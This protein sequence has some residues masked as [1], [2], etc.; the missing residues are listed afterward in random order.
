MKTIKD[1][2][3]HSRPREKLQEKLTMT[4]IVEHIR[5]VREELIKRY[6]GIDGYFQHCRALDRAWAARS[7][8]R[9][10]KEPAHTARK[11]SKSK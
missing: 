10:R 5:Q 3:E 9:R 4:D 11:H 1:L 2:P 7:K 8:S 6:G